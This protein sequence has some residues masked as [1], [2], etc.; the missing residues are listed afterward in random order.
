LNQVLGTDTYD[1][2]D[3]CTSG[4]TAVSKVVFGSEAGI[5]LEDGCPEP[6]GG[7]SG[8]NNP[9]TKNTNA[10]ALEQRGDSNYTI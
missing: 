9:V 7:P 5:H 10:A 8:N 1:G 4:N 6:D 3:S 2:I